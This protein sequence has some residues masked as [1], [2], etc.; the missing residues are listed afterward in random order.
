MRDE[1]VL[2]SLILHLTIIYLIDAPG[3]RVF[4]FH[5]NINRAIRTNENGEIAGDVYVVRNG[6]W[7]FEN[8]KVS[9]KNGD[10]LYYWIYVQVEGSTYRRDNK[11]TY[12]CKR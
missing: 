8:S 3:L 12:R 4:G 1:E 6:H 9:I 10:E 7:T 2:F 5:A 11:W